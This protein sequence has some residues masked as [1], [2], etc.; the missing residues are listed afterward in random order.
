MQNRMKQV[1]LLSKLPRDIFKRS[2][3]GSPGRAL[4]H[5]DGI[6][7]FPEL[8]DVFDPEL[9]VFTVGVEQIDTADLVTERAGSPEAGSNGGK[10][11]H[12]DDRPG[13][14]QTLVGPGHHQS[15]EQAGLVGTRL[16]FAAEPACRRCRPTGSCRSVCRRVWHRL[17]QG[18]AVRQA[19]WWHCL[20]GSRDGPNCL[21]KGGGSIERGPPWAKAEPVQ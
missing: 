19:R 12:S 1:A 3:G 4:N 5:H 11:R 20:V 14:G 17:A 7:V 18:Q 8:P 13:P 9:V 10:Y 2:D 16:V 21:S 6:I 15:A